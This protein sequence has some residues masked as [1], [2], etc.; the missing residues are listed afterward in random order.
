MICAVVV[1]FSFQLDQLLDLSIGP[2]L[3]LAR[4]GQATRRPQLEK[5]A[6]YEYLH[7]A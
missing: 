6:E 4:L 5:T 2:D 3:D 7:L 1:T